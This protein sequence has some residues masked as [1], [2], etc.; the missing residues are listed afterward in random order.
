MAAAIVVLIMCALGAG[1][2]EA[3]A[4]QVAL[5]FLCVC[6]AAARY[7]QVIIVNQTPR[8]TRRVCAFAVCA[9]AIAAHLLVPA[10]HPVW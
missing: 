10:A 8:P 7:Y 6:G 1:N 2:G 3:R 9:A 4:D 5:T